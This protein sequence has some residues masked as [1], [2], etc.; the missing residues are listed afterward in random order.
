MTNKVEIVAG[1]FSRAFTCRSTASTPAGA[2]RNER[3]T[4]RVAVVNGR[5]GQRTSI[6][7]R[8]NRVD[9]V[10]STQLETLES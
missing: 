3:M 1:D 4:V 10:E 9:E 8:L 2:T 6:I 5:E 7:Q